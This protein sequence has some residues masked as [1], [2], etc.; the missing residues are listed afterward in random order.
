MEKINSISFK[1]ENSKK[2]KKN[3]KGSLAS[4]AIGIITTKASLPVS[5]FAAKKM[6]KL[7]GSL[8]TDEK[9]ILNAAVDN[10]LNNKTN[11]AKKGAVIKNTTNSPGGF[12]KNI[13]LINR[14]DFPLSTFHEM[15]HAF[16]FNNSVFWKTMQKMRRAGTALTS[17]ILFFVAFS[18]ESKPQDGKELTK[19]QKF[20]N[21]LR[22]YSPALVAAAM[23]PTVLEEGMATLRGNKWAREVFEKTPKLAKKVSKTNKWGFISYCA[24]TAGI[25]FS[26]HIVR[27]IKDLSTAKK[28]GFAQFNSKMEAHQG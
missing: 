14:D 4:Y 8:N 23:L 5:Y 27:R 15:G 13:I 25:A 10:V 2:Q 18:K 1:G 3:L 16:N 24:M 19:A 12:L 7:S 9:G 22:K 6:L 17:L 28:E 26:A 20:K 11:L 21:N